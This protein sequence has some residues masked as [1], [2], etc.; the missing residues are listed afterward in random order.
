MNR[1]AGEGIHDPEEGVTPSGFIVTGAS[2]S[3][4]P[5]AFEPVLEAAAGAFSAKGASLYL[6]GSVATGT[7]RVPDSDVDLVSIGLPP[8]DASRLSSALSGQFRDLCRSVAIGPGQPSD[9]EGDDDE[10]YGH[11]VFLRHYC[12]HLA[13]PDFRSALPD[14]AADARAARGFNGDIAEHAE[15]WREALA[16]GDDPV[17]LS[18]RIGRKCLF[19]V[20]GLVSIHD[21]RWTT[22]RAAA[23]QRWA[24]VEPALAGSLQVLLQWSRGQGSPDRQAVEAA[25]DGIV[26]EIVESFEIQIGLWNRR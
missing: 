11:R 3:R 7:A 19:A 8:E 15:R 17:V 5:A 13:G 1:S 4:V 9:Y 25:L 16:D 23:A 21:H 24:E 10:A 26:A 20:A 14:V 12:V 18:R 22:D 2:R 6:Y